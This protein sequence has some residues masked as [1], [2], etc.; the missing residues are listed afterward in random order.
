ML[1]EYIFIK[2]DDININNIKEIIYLKVTKFII[3]INDS[4]KMPSD[5]SPRDYLIK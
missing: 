2:N 4:K 5:E 1:K 3:N